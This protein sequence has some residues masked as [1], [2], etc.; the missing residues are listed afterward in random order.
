VFRATALPP[1]PLGCKETPAFPGLLAPPQATGASRR[2]NTV[3]TAYI[4]RLRA[5]MDP[6]AALVEILHLY[7]AQGTQPS[8]AAAAAAAAATAQ[9]PPLQ[10][11]PGQASGGGAP[12]G[13]GGL[14]LGQPPQRSIALPPGGGAAGQ[15]QQAR[16]ASPPLWQLAGIP[17]RAPQ[18]HGAPLRSDS[19]QGLM[20]PGTGAGATGAMSVGLL[21]LPS[22]SV[23]LP[24]APPLHLGLGLGL[25][26]GAPQAG[27]FQ[28]QPQVSAPPL[29]RGGSGGTF[30]AAGAGGPAGPQQRLPPF[31]AEGAAPQPLASPPRAA[32]EGAAAAA[33]AAAGGPSMPLQHP[34]QSTSSSTLH[35]SPGMTPL[36]AAAVSA[37]AGG[38]GGGGVGAAAAGQLAATA[39]AAAAA[40]LPAVPRALGAFGADGWGPGGFGAAAAATQLQ[41]AFAAPPPSFAGPPLAGGGPWWAP[42][43]GAGWAAAG[44]PAGDATALREAVLEASAVAAASAESWVTPD[45]PGFD[46]PVLPAPLPAAAAA[47]VA[48]VRSGARA[49]LWQLEPASAPPAP[50]PPGGLLQHQPRQQQQQCNPLSQ[51]LQ[52][53][54]QPQLQGA[55]GPHGTQAGLQQQG[56]GGFGWGGAGARALRRTGSLSAGAPYDVPVQPLVLP[57]ASGAGADAGAFLSSASRAG[58]GV[59]LQLRQQGGGVGP[60][61]IAAGDGLESEQAAPGDGGSH[62]FWV[63]ELMRDLQED[64]DDDEV[65]G[66]G[67]GA[68]AGQGPGAAA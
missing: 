16:P 39:P 21:G 10:L 46:V 15:L 57:P 26:G 32:G 64:E 7:S 58:G 50:P 63:S 5:G 13:A 33:A 22:G 20:G 45:D 48:R 27:L 8:S 18:Q 68:G 11:A 2:R 12:G 53:Y 30:A 44:A 24:H 54:G 29:L 67:S 1:H 40:A 51:Q 31:A 17:Q 42:A 59:P 28:L 23:E 60:A 19:M 55:G 41:Q 66:G 35:L 65:Q 49:L 56:Q 43:G 52:R 38:G 47:A 36:A 61:A 4:S 37:G 3:L 25:P 9:L 62:Q 34:R 14:P 6:A